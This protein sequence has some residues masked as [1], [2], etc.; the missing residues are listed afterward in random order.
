MIL[1]AV[2]FFYCLIL[3]LF[4]FQSI[5]Y[6]LWGARNNFRFYIFFFAVVMFLTEE[7]AERF[8]VALD[9]VFW[10]N[11]LV[12][13][14]QYFGFGYMQDYLGGIFGVDSGVNA[15]SIIF[16]SIVLSRSLLRYMEQKEH[17]GLCAAKCSMALVIS[18]LA[19][20]KFFFVF[21]LIIL[22][23]AAVLTAFSWRKLLILALCA[24]LI[25]LCST[26]LVLLFDFED[27]LSLENIWK[28]ATQEYYS[29]AQTV[30]RLSAI[31]TLSKMLVTEFNERLFGLGLGNCDTSSFD[32]CNTPFYQL[33]G[34]LRY[35]FFSVAFLFLEVGYLGLLL[36]T[37]FFVFCFVM[38]YRRIKLQLCN[39]HHGQVGLIM[40]VLA[41]ILILYNSSLRAEAGYIVYFVLAL[42]FLSTDVGE[43]EA[44]PEKIEN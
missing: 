12:T 29:S 42:P 31:P 22:I 9:A 3:Y 34:Y 35:T 37:A 4:R 43:K 10:F 21:F 40:A 28:V 7:D 26:L 1:V 18:A 2:F 14:V 38:I 6:F 17:F 27:F 11:A 32:I 8:F 24:G 5:I 15:L 44:I 20:L 13:L 19:E 33:H 30:N 41:V 16:F 23:M 36:Y 39:R 25:S